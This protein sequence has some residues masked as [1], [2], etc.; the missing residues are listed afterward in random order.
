MVLSHTKSSRSGVL[1]GEKESEGPQLD[2][3]NVFYEW[4]QSFQS[5]ELQKQNDL[6][7]HRRSADQITE[8]AKMVRTRL[9]ESA[10]SLQRSQ[11]LS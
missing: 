9:L 2:L 5:T 1:L 11:I 8:R 4:F 6:P 7:E 10:N 3:M